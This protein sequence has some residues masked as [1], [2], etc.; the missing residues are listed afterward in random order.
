MDSLDLIL[1]LLGGYS[2]I[3]WGVVAY[4]LGGYESFK[5]NNSII[6]AIYSASP[7]GGEDD[8]AGD[9]REAKDEMRHEVENQGRFF[10]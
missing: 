4:S 3:L 7:G 8:P 10:Y 9:L 6:G 1:G 5:F 2:A